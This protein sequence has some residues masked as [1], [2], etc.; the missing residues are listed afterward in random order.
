MLEI[1]ASHM[2]NHHMVAAAGGGRHHVVR[3][4][5]RQPHIMWAANIFSVC[6]LWL[7]LYFLFCRIFGFLFLPHIVFSSAR[8]NSF[9]VIYSY[10]YLAMS[11][12]D[13]SVLELRHLGSKFV[14]SAS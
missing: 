12:C 14:E 3:G 2:M 7:R 6:L 11:H 1:L 13:Y 9:P 8:F 5:R 10:S 4:G